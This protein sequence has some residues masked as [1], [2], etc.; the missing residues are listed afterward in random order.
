[1]FLF[2]MVW[3]LRGSY[4]ELF[5]STDSFSVVRIPFRCLVLYH[6][7]QIIELLDR[8]TV[9]IEELILKTSMIS[10]QDKIFPLFKPQIVDRVD[11]HMPYIK[12]KL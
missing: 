3:N 1:M 2:Q 7:E 10:V 5:F 12:V 11:P 4:Y 8:H 9:P 6:F